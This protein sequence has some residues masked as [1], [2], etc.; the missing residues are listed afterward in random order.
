[1]W[2][3]THGTDHSIARRVTLV[4]ALAVITVVTGTSPM[5]AQTPAGGAKQAV[6]TV[7]GMQCPF[8]AYGIKKH[9]AKIAGVKKVDVDLAKHQA[10]VQFAPDAKPTDQQIQQAVKDAGFTPGKIEWRSGGKGDKAEASVPGR[11]G[12]AH[13]QTATLAIGHALYRM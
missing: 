9:L 3:N 7:K 13:E 2:T 4:L 5:N 6:V 11:A 12:T 10:I 8:C 1:M